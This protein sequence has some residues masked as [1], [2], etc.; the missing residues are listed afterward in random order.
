MTI[1]IGVREFR[2]KLSHYLAE[3]QHG[4]DIVITSHGKPIAGL[5]APV[6]V[7]RKKRPVPQ[8]GTL[9]GKIW[10]ADNFDEPDEEFNAAYEGRT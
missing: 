1:H 7:E 6:E 4:T 9:K 10:I 2:E 3:V 8:F 5:K